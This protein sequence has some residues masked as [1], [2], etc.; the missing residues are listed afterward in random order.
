[1]PIHHLDQFSVMYSHLLMIP[2]IFPLNNRSLLASTETE[3]QFNLQSVY[4]QY[5]LKPKANLVY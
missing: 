1:M 3:S 4:F 5:L 2:Y